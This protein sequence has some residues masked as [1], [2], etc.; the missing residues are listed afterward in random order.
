MTD[1]IESKEF[2]LVNLKVTKSDNEVRVWAC[3]PKTGQN[4]FRL[5]AMGKVYAAVIYD[6]VVKPE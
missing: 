5:K 1:K 6:I 2:G 3:D 4:C